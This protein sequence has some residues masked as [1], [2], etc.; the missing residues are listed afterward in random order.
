MNKKSRM[1]II[2]LAIL[3][4]NT[5]G[6][7]VWAAELCSS[8]SQQALPIQMSKMGMLRIKGQPGMERAEAKSLQAAKSKG[9]ERYQKP[10]LIDKGACHYKASGFNQSTVKM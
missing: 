10:I 4:S 9:F 7:A 1:I 3:L 5:T 2:V 6:S 8:E